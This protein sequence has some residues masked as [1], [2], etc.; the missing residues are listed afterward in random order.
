[1]TYTALPHILA[2]AHRLRRLIEQERSLPGATR[3]RL[4][5]LQRLLLKMQARLAAVL[6]TRP[7]ALAH[8]R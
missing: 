3:L 1:M 7:A 5:R 6:Q 4:M 2:R 8:V